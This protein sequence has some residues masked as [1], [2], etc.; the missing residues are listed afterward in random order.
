[1]RKWL[2]IGLVIVV[3]LSLVVGLLGP[4]VASAKAKTATD[5]VKAFIKSLPNLKK[6]AVTAGYWVPDKQASVKTQLE[7]IPKDTK[8]KISLSK[9]KATGED[10]GPATVTAVSKLE[11]QYKK[12]K[13]KR[14]AQTITF[15]L[16][17]K[18]DPKKYV[19]LISNSHS[20]SYFRFYR[21][22]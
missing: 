7:A 16:E 11:L 13:E 14:A 10:G 15:S 6:T 22:S 2:S 18:G 19:W 12:V 21:T 4:T 5:T 9:Y 20:Y 17:K 1:M 3:A 8:I